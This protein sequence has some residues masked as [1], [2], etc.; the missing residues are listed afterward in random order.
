MDKEIIENKFEIHQK[1]EAFSSEYWVNFEE[2]LF[3]NRNKAPK[4]KEIKDVLNYN[5]ED[6]YNQRSQID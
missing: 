5:E 3:E 6:L 4:K 1:N 2:I